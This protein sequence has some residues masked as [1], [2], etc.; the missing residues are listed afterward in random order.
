ME[1]CPYCDSE[2]D[3]ENPFCE[4]CG[5]L[6]HVLVPYVPKEEDYVSPPHASSK[7]FQVYIQPAHLPER[8]YTG[9]TVFYFVIAL[10]ISLAGMFSLFATIGSTTRVMALAI[11]CS[12]ALT[13]GSIVVFNVRRKK[14]SRLST[15]ALVICMLGATLGGFMAFCLEIFIVP[16]IAQG[17]HAQLGAGLTSAIIMIYGLTLETMA[18]W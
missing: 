10:P 18:L 3:G 1:K 11:A 2:N 7:F 5:T 9:R 15:Q 13:Y 8:G 16:D 4:H 6:M 17:G 12:L 14:Q